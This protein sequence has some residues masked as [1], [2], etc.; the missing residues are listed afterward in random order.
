MNKDTKQSELINRACV[1]WC[2]NAYDPPSARASVAPSSGLLVGFRLENSSRGPG[3]LGLGLGLEDQGRID[4][5]LMC[6]SVS[7]ICAASLIQFCM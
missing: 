3:S 1:L 5:H 4:A 7:C 2:T 6:A